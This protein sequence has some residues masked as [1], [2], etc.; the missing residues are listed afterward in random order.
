MHYPAVQS[1]VLLVLACCGCNAGNS[2]TCY[3]PD[4]PTVPAPGWICDAPGSG[5]M[6][7]AVGFAPKSDAGE[8]RTRQ[9][10]TRDARTRLTQE[11]GDYV[12]ESRDASGKITQTRISESVLSNVRVLNSA[13][14]PNGG[15]YVQLG[16]ERHA[17][18]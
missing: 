12:T 8:P 13:K 18:H 4:A 17:G 6:L 5:E 15:Y 14:S 7:T 3:F 11:P 1:I 10:A 2:R 9:M 16:M